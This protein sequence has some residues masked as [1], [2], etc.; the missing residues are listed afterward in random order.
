MRLRSLTLLCLAGAWHASTLLADVYVDA[1]TG[2]DQTGTGTQAAPVQTLTRGIELLS[3]GETLFIAPGDYYEDNVVIDGKGG[4]A[5]NYTEI[6][7]IRPG[8]VRILGTWEEA[9]TGNLVWEPQGNGIYR[10]AIPRALSSMSGMYGDV[11]LHRLDYNQRQDMI[12][13]VART[14]A[15]TFNAPDYAF[16][17][18]AQRHYYVRLPGSEDPN[19]KEIHFA[20]PYLNN[21]K[22]ILEVKN[23]PYLHFDGI[24]LV[25][26]GSHGIRFTRNSTH[27]IVSNCV[28]TMCN[29]GV[30]VADY[31]LIE[32]SEYTFPGLRRFFDDINALNPSE[33]DSNLIFQWVKQYSTRRIEGGL[34]EATDEGHDSRTDWDSPSAEGGEFR[35]NFV[36]QA[37][38]GEQ[39]GTLN[40]SSSHHSVYID[41]FDNAIQFD[42]RGNEQSAINLHVHDSYFEGHSFGVISHQEQFSRS[43]Y[44]GP[45]YVYRCVFNMTRTEQWHPHWF[46]KSMT[47]SD[48]ES[49]EYYHNLFM[50]SQHALF[51]NR[52]E[53]QAGI[54]N[55]KFANNLF[56]FTRRMGGNLSAGNTAAQFENN[57]LVNESANGFVTGKGGLY[58][59]RHIDGAMLVNPGDLAWQPAEG[60]PLIDAGVVLDVPA[61]PDL[62][63]NAV[64]LPD[65]GPFEFGEVAGP[66]WPRPYDRP[67]TGSGPV[68]DREIIFLE[69]EE[70]NFVTGGEVT[71]AIGSAGGSGGA[72]LFLNNAEL[73]SY[74][75][76]PINNVPAGVYR[77]EIGNRYR[78]NYG[79]VDVSINGVS[80]GLIDLFWPPEDAVFQ[81]VAFNDVQLSGGTVNVRVTLVGTNPEATNDS[82]SFDYVR[83]VPIASTNPSYWAAL[84][85]ENG[86]KNTATDTHGGI[87]WIDDAHWPW[88]YTYGIG[89]G[90]WLYILEGGSAESFYAY[91]RGNSSWLFVHPGWGYYYDYTNDAWSPLN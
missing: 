86:F 78:K 53:D 16:Y 28:F 17:I 91:H 11:F 9:A 84:P 5:E 39:L 58:L 14:N 66:E 7:A 72:F 79:V 82:Y 52:S 88:V 36:H 54:A 83:L 73:E 38:D 23:S 22:P 77:V 89:E 61:I 46:L 65:V 49:I 64:G 67:D 1:T 29:V 55:L 33:L 15:G 41:V 42:H 70:A 32:W 81:E 43:P 71:V 59:G 68:D 63:A 2:S 90:V 37:F 18:D 40:N 25:G 62:Q 48:I 8:T 34:Y 3:G 24:E 10:S 51:S 57:F 12:D 60:S 35:Y 4:T 21:R 31:T 6:R 69:A 44:L 85:V 50:V 45:N 87:G 27:G 74:V 47:G 13:Q 75:E 80:L 76:L 56:V 19:G 20:R 30:G 26:G